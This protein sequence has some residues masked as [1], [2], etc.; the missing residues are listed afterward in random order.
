MKFAQETDT[1]GYTIKGYGDDGITV[2]LPAREHTAEN[3]GE[4]QMSHSFVLSHEVLLDDWPPQQLEELAAEHF[5]R[6]ADLEPEV[7]IFG[8]GESLRFPPTEVTAP[9]VKRGVGLEVMDS[10]AACRTYNILSAEGR[11]VVAALLIP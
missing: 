3:R 7:V 8:A 6:V 5:E 4:R 9:L 11:R 1:S 2:A 10:R